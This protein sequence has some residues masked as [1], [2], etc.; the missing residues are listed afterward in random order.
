MYRCCHSRRKERTRTVTLKF[1]RSELIYD[2]GNYAYIEADIID[3]RN[4]RNDHAQHQ[5]FDVVQD[6]NI[7]RVTRS[8]DLAHSKCV[9]LLYPYTKTKVPEKS[10]RDDILKENPVYLIEMVVPDDFSDSTVSLLENLV[11]EYL[12][13]YVLYDWF[14]MTLPGSAAAYRNKMSDLESEIATAKSIRMRRVRRTM[15]PF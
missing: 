9:E 15:S 3:P 14:M 8:L 6:G 2:I 10:E 12:I 1:F 4:P 11:H 5:V 13:C 7:D